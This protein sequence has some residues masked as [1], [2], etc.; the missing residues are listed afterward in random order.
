MQK[1]EQRLFKVKSTDNGWKKPDL[2]YGGCS[3]NDI[4]KDNLVSKYIS[5]PLQTLFPVTKPCWQDE[6][7]SKVSNISV[8]N[9]S[10][11]NRDFNKGMNK[12]ISVLDLS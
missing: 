4:L 3:Q 1:D 5:S 9:K 12:E 2:L 10:K 8:S 7:P 6:T 11:N